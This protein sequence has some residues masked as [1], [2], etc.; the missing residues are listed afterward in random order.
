MR[1]YKLAVMMLIFALILPLVAAPVLASS[2]GDPLQ[3]FIWFNAAKS[4][5]H[6]LVVNPTDKI[7]NLEFPSGKEFDVEI[8]QNDKKFWRLSDGQSYTMAVK[9]E[10]L[11]PGGTKLYR[12][13]LPTLAE[14]KY[15]VLAYFEGGVSRGKA[16]AS[17]PL[18]IVTNPIVSALQYKISNENG[19]ITFTVTNPSDKAVD[20]TFNGG[21]K[22]DLA[23]FNKVGE[24]VWQLSEGQFYILPIIHEKIESGKSQVYEAQLPKLPAG[25]YTVK[26]F[27][28]GQGTNDAV[29]STNITVAAQQIKH[30]LNFKLFFKNA[31]N[32]QI[33]LRIRNNS[34][35]TVRLE[36]PTSK[37]MD[38][39]VKGDNGF[40]WRQ[41]DGKVFTPA[42]RAHEIRTGVT[43]FHFIHLPRLPRGNYTVEAFYYGVSE[44]P[45]TTSSFSIR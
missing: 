45:V 10:K 42:V 11:Q 35:S 32:P 19:K 36:T 6:I 1:N 20:L 14:G 2:T 24:K 30:N 44:K 22:F 28:F 25:E 27:F 3:H 41:S 5:V 34:G 31:R 37:I 29:A 4:E 43:R 13:S 17:A 16:V 18:N 38:I 7:V 40:S 33:T 26:A 15:Q 12:A 9:M 21:K 8:R 39:V 23:V